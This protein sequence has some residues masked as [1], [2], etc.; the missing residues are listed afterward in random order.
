[1]KSKY[2]IVTGMDDVTPDKSALWQEVE[3]ILRQV[4]A[5]FGYQ[6]IRTPSLEKAEMFKQNIGVETDVV[7]KQ[8]FYIAIDEDIK[9]KEQLVLKPEMTA[10]VVRAYM[11]GGLW[12]S[13]PL[14]KLYYI[15]SFFRRERQQKGRRRQFHQFGVEVLGGG[16][17]TDQ[18]AEVILFAWTCMEKLKIKNKKLVI[19]NIGTIKERQE[20]QKELEK[21][22]QKHKEK[23]SDESKERLQRNPMRIL[24]SKEKEDQ[25]II[26]NAPKI[27]TVEDYASNKFKKLKENLEALGIPY[28]HNPYLV[29][30]LDYYNG[31]VFEITTESNK[32]QNALCGGGRFD[33]L[34][35][36]MGGKKTSAVGFAAG[37]ERMIDESD[38]ENE[39]NQI[40]AYIVCNGTEYYDK[41]LQL[42]QKLIEKKYSIFFDTRK[43]KVKE[44]RIRKHN[45]KFGIWVGQ[46]DK[47]LYWSRK[48]P[49]KKDNNPIIS[50]NIDEFLNKLKTQ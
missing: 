26:K 11:E 33:H 42:I 18:D 38:L 46:K 28:Q 31:N 16:Y 29:R 43:G 15:D 30:G 41:T 6:E 37:I 24:D 36:N 20:W 21:Y 12:R 39:N 19:N 22:F 40:D 32:S 50:D 35:E 9:D 48:L 27:D 45:A 23:L 14:S 5:Q 34:V 10:P 1:V 47:P 3:S 8:M 17:G 4:S 44:D 49:F 7:S 13:K 25:T 2:Q